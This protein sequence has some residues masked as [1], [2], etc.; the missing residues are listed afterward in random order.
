MNNKIIGFMWLNGEKLSMPSTQKKKHNFLFP[1]RFMNSVSPRGRFSARLETGRCSQEIV[2]R[3]ARLTRL[4]C[5]GNRIHDEKKWRPLSA[6]DWFGKLFPSAASVHRPSSVAILMVPSRK[7]QQD[8][9]V[10][11]IL[12]PR[13]VFVWFSMSFFANHFL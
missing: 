13:L 5:A 12:N 3:P 10:Q 6:A 7:K 4:I 11:L 8:A 2:G 9:L 1:G